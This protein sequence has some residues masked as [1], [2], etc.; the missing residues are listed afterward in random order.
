MEQAITDVSN[1]KESQPMQVHTAGS[2]QRTDASDTTSS[3]QIIVM[4]LAVNREQMQS[5][6]GQEAELLPR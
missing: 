1:I 4:Q 3:Q 5:K 2:Q 6:P